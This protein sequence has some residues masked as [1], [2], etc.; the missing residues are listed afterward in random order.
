MPR[1]AHSTSTYNPLAAT[2]LGPTQSQ[3]A[4]KRHSP[5]A[6][7]PRAQKAGSWKYLA[8]ITDDFHIIITYFSASKST[9][10]STGHMKK[11]TLSRY[12]SKFLRKRILLAQLD[13][14]R[15]TGGPIH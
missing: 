10:Y 6:I 14:E 7:L 11:E 3:G 5:R 8:S 9:C 1:S 13:S 12:N 4:Q 15:P 2:E